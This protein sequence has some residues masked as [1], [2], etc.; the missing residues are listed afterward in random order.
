MKQLIYL[1]AFTCLLRISQLSA[2]APE[3]EWDN[4]IGGNDYDVL[5]SLQPTTDGGYILGGVSSSGISEDKSESSTWT[6]YWVVKLNADGTIEWDN[7]LA[8]TQEDFLSSIIQTSDN[9]YLAAGYS[10]SNASD[11]KSENSKGSNDYWV[12]KLDSTGETEWD[13]TIGAKN[14]IAYGDEHL[15]DDRLTSV[16]QTSALSF[17][18]Q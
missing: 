3:I 4:T 11:D 1:S 18:I 10:E 5:V 6:D 15:G 8:G 16:E 14:F 17:T 7:T 2:Q 13:N 9:G 12:I